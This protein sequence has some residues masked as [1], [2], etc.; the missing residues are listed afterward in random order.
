MVWKTLLAQCKLRKSRLVQ[1]SQNALLSN[2][3]LRVKGKAIKIPTPDKLWT[4]FP[5]RVSPIGTDVLDAVS[6]HVLKNNA[7]QSIILDVTPGP[8]FLVDKIIKSGC[9][10]LH[11]F[12]HHQS[13]YYPLLEVQ[14]AIV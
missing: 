3:N 7:S 6:E 9:N 4:F 1:L 8:G 11:L 2:A 10:H 14:L 5:P 12:E 13:E